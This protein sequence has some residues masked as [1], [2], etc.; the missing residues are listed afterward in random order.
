M[1]DEEVRSLEWHD[2]VDIILPFVF[3]ITTPQGSGTGFLVSHSAIQPIIGIAT[4]AHVIDQAHWWEQPIRVEHYQSNQS[5]LLRAAE[6]AV[7]T[8][9]Q[10]D[11]AAIVMNKG[12]FPLATE[13]PALIPDEMFV[14]VGV[15]VSWLGFPS[16]YPSNSCF[17]SGRVSCHLPGEHAYLVDGVAI[18]GV[19]GGPALFLAHDRVLVIG[20]VSA[21]IAN[22]AT[23][24]TLPGVSVIRD[25]SQFHELVRSFRSVDEAKQEEAPLPAQPPPAN[26]E[27]AT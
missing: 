11:T 25:V 1:I 2:A 22:R 17:F 23:G 12:S 14:K 6:R 10:K 13:P 8:E 15:E 18:N 19:S 4:A 5:V 21:Y 20:V 3:R 24:E 9:A 7:I 26:P 27:G 16:V